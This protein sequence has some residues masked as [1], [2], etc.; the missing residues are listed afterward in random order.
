VPKA[1]QRRVHLV[2]DPPVPIEMAEHRVTF[3]GITLLNRAVMVEYLAEPPLRPFY[4]F[5][6]AFD[7]V[8]IDDVEGIP[9]PTAY[10]NLARPE[11]GPGQ[12]TTTLSARPS[13][14]ATTLRFVIR[15]SAGADPCGGFEV[16]LPPE[17]GAPWRPDHTNEESARTRAYETA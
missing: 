17:H 10:E 14:R 5:D 9:Y 6:P 12:A 2:L 13:A 3:T 15:P 1:K 11:R 8:V 16:S 7:L 4:P